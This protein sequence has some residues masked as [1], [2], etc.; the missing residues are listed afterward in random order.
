MTSPLGMSAEEKISFVSAVDMLRLQS[1]ADP[2][3]KLNEYERALLLADE[4]IQ[5]LD[6]RNTN[7]GNEYRRLDEV[8]DSVMR[9]MR[10]LRQ[11][12]EVAKGGTLVGE[13]VAIGAALRDLQR[14]LGLQPDEELTNGEQV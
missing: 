2:D 13:V 3:M 8:V 4:H 10:S 7:L 12:Y 9:Y 5:A 11:A 6:R 14:A 1:R